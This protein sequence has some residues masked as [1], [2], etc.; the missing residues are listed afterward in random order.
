MK[1][2]AL[3]HLLNN[4][5]WETLHA[6]IGTELMKHILTSDGVFVLEKQGSAYIQTIGRNLGKL[7]MAELQKG[8]TPAVQRDSITSYA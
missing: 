5:N 7:A 4:A 2:F 1:N 6:M 8:T 3:E